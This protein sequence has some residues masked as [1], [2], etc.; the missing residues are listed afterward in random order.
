MKTDA[1]IRE[2]AESLRPVRI[3]PSPPVRLFTWAALAVAAT[4]ALI[5]AV[6][7]RMPEVFDASLFIHFESASALLASLFAAALALY[8]A[9]PGERL[10]LL[11]AGLFL[12]LTAWIGSVS[13]R[14]AGA[15]GAF[16][17]PAVS[18]I[19]CARDVLLGGFLSSGILLGMLK[20]AA[21]LRP[22]LTASLAALAASLVGIVALQFFCHVQS[23][24]HIVSCHV[25]PAV[26]FTA[27]G[28]VVGRR[29]LG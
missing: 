5:G 24:W 17:L 10:S 18:E 4:F 22:T 2:L 20:R 28:T 21:P 29:L 16:T 3:L 27:L 19:Y 6:R 15:Q 25:A 12:A 23:P 7:F 1:L 13:V 26:L 9:I 14:W 8:V 11:P